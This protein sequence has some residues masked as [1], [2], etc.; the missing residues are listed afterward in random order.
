MSDSK[1]D[2][3]LGRAS[4]IMAIILSA[5]AC[6]KSP[7]D[8]KAATIPLPPKEA[9]NQ[10]QQAFSAANAEVKT[11]AAVASEAIRT[12]DYPKA[13]N[14]IQNIKA[15][16]DLTF[17]QGVAVYNSEVALETALLARVAANDP[18]A[19]QAYE[20]LKKSKRN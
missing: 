15:R 10:M 7:N 3:T 16:K 2:S 11:R 20:E 1:T 5:S 14:A 6:N 17:E 13:I 4:L 19:K 8:T 18:A 12:A 9:A